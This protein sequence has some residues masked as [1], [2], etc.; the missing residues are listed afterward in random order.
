VP[1]ASVGTPSIYYRQAL[2]VAELGAG[3]R[4]SCRSR[5]GTAEM[6]FIVVK[7]EGRMGLW[8]CRGNW[9]GWQLGLNVLSCPIHCLMSQ[10]VWGSSCRIRSG[11][12]HGWVLGWYHIA[13]EVGLGLELEEVEVSGWSLVQIPTSHR[14][15]QVIWMMVVVLSRVKWLELY[16]YDSSH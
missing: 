15:F 9:G 11:C 2:G 12:G 10:W 3:M 7:R 13:V 16:S 14:R 8:R 6:F 5:V 4:Y 1:E